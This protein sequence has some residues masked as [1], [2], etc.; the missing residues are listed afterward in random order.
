MTA[1][2]SAQETVQHL[3]PPGT[4]I[5][6]VEVSLVVPALDEELTAGEF[7][8]WCKQGLSKACVK[9]QILI[10]DSSTDKTPEIALAHGAEVLKTPKRGLGRAYLDAIPYIRGKYV[11]MGDADLTYDFREIE[12]FV[13]KFRAGYEYIMGSRFKGTIEK[14]A[15]PPHHQYF[16]TPLT[17]WLLN[18][19]YGTGFSDIHCGIRGVTLDGLIRMDLRS[20]A[21][22]YASEMII[23]ARHLRLRTTEVPVPFYRDREGRESHIKRGGWFTPWKIGWLTLQ[24]IFT[25]GADVLLTGPGIFLFLFGLIW[26]MLLYNGPVAIPSLGLS[27][28][29]HWMLFF[30]LC[31][32]VGLQLF[33]VGIFARVIYDLEKRTVQKW[34]PYFNFTFS[35]VVSAALF[36]FGLISLRGIVIKYL[37]GLPFELRDASS[38][39]AVAGVGLILASVVYFTSALIFNALLLYYPRTNRGGQVDIHPATQEEDSA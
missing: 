2:E 6:P 18:R 36:L 20:Q 15:M 35:V 21:W 13:E 10:I 37:S 31:C 32:L 3:V 38:F 33:L 34:A 25:H 14:G 28:H 16:G 4:K 27:F 12:P 26:V 5:E 9:G 22:Q 8:E 7:V 19:F 17:T 11:I 1:Q 30:L 29:L 24:V 39:Q 23:K